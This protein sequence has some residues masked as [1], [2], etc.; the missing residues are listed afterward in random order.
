MDKLACTKGGAKGRGWAE[1]VQ[2]VID[3]LDC[4]VKG[5]SFLK[6]GKE[7]FER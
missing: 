7:M 4:I 2:V 6:R 1:N 3:Y 5:C